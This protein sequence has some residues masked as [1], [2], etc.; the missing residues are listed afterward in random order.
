ELLRFSMEGAR[1]PEISLRRE[2][3]LLDRYLDIMQLRFQ[4]RLEVARRVDDAALDMLVPSMVLQPLVENAIKHGVEKITGPGRIDLDAQLENGVLVLRVSDNGPGWA[5]DASPM[6]DGI[7]LRNTAARLEQLYGGAARFTLSRRPDG[8][9]VAE[10]RVPA[11]SAS[12]L[13]VQGVDVTAG[14][15]QHVR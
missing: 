4:G 14:E 7:G 6:R 8:I 9:T 5:P 1:D 12:E 10:L 11:R 2:L 13:R 15:A 3:D